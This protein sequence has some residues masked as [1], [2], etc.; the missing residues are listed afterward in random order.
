MKI[1]LTCTIWLLSI[2]TASA[3]YFSGVV[4]YRVRIIPKVKGL[5][6]DSI[7][8]LQPGTS[9]VYMASGF[10]KSTYYKA[11]KE[12]YSYTYHGDTKRMYDAYDKFDYITFRDSRKS[13]T[14]RIR[15][16]IY[17]DS[18]RKVA[19]HTCFMVERVYQNYIS[20]TYYATDL[21]IDTESFKDHAT[22]DWYNQIKEVG[23]AL[24]L[25]SVNEYATYFEYY[26]VIR[27]TPKKLIPSDFAL[28]S[29]KAVVASSDALDTQVQLI[30]PTPE[31]VECYRTKISNALID[32]AMVDYV[33]YISLLVSANGQIMQATPYENDDHGFYKTA[34]DIVE[35]CGLKFSPGQIDGVAVDA[36][37]YFPIGFQKN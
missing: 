12:V 26:E 25:G 18:I 4:E 35:N 32:I 28:P 30:E 37:V 8:A 9:S 5:N 19:G 7:M 24:S 27:V 15:S 22:G 34:L 20:K 11:D 3:Q 36:Q 10:Y 21:K 1:L 6:T 14:T 2:A 13:N 31:T 23:G 17:K 16:I 29:Q 33:S